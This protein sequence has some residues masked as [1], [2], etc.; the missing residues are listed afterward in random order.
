L[1]ALSRVRENPRHPCNTQRVIAFSGTGAVQYAATWRG[2]HA[3]PGIFL[4]AG[5]DIGHRT[6]V[7]HV[8]YFDIVPTVL[9]PQH[10][11][12]SSEMRARSIDHS[13]DEGF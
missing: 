8:S 6:N 7:E 1:Y 11:E 5:P 2:G 9:D 3:S 4:A 13:S 10:F 12:K